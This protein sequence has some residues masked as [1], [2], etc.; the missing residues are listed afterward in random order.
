M[1]RI[2]AVRE[3]MRF[4]LI[5][6]LLV[7]L[8]SCGKGTDELPSS[9]ESM[10]RVV[11]RVQEKDPDQ[12]YRMLWQRSFPEEYQELILRAEKIRR[13]ED[14][15]YAQPIKVPDSELTP[16]AFAN[17][18]EWGKGLPSVVFEQLGFPI[19]DVEEGVL[20]DRGRRVHWDFQTGV[21]EIHH[22]AQAI[23]AFRSRFPEFEDE[24]DDAA[25]KTRLNNLLPRA[26]SK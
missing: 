10:Q 20:V 11:L 14:H 13:G 2:D 23:T 4:I 18:N 16:S 12:V 26:E 24:V 22:S 6:Q 7:V 19:F 1:P 21:I 9:E 15:P 8:V 17:V 25:N 5:S 3:K